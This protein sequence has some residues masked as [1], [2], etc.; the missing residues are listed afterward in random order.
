VTLLNKLSVACKE[1]EESCSSTSCNQ[2]V[3]PRRISVQRRDWRNHRFVWISSLRSSS[4]HFISLLLKWKIS[5]TCSLFLFLI[6][7]FLEKHIL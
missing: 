3:E 1:R 7:S 4:M 2:R 6:A 5:D